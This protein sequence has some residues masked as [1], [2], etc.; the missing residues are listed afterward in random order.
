[1]AYSMGRRFLLEQES[2]GFVLRSLTHFHVSCLLAL[3]SLNDPRLN[4]PARLER[5]RDKT[6]NNRKPK[7]YL[8][9]RWLSL[10]KFDA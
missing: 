10:A 4:I 9:G 2:L 3:V 7:K 6:L 5:S 1:M 8:E